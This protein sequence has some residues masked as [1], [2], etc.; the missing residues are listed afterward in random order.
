MSKF[1]ASINLDMNLAASTL[2]MHAELKTPP[3][4][5]TPERYAE[6]VLVARIL[7][8]RNKRLPTPRRQ[9]AA[10]GGAVQ[11][12]VCKWNSLDKS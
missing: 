10:Y 6:G 3:S 4:S 9:M 12:D 11:S 5:L 2:N 1:F 7:Q 8:K